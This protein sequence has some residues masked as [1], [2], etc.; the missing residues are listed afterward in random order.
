MNYSQYPC[1]SSVKWIKI[2]LGIYTGQKKVVVFIFNYSHT[3]ITCRTSQLLLRAD[4]YI[5]WIS[6]L[7]ANYNLNKHLSIGESKNY[8]QF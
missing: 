8:V 7:Y 3:N 2:V 1:S 5:S 6:E 4:F